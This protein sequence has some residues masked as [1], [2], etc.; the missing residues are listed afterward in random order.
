[1]NLQDVFYHGVRQ[2]L[3]RVL[4]AMGPER[5]D[6]GLT[7]FED[8]ASNWS[9]CFFARAYPDLELDNYHRDS[10]PEWMLANELGFKTLLPIRMV[11]CTFDGAG[12]T[13][14]KDQLRKFVEDVRDDLRPDAVNELLRTLDFSKVESDE[15]LSSCR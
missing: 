1:M 3:R 11:Y 9:N 13:M 5:V 4:V 12:A 6:M 7:A 14:T 8:G 2:Q 10:K 15:A